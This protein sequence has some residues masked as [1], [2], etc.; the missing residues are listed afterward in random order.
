MLLL[1]GSL[2]RLLRDAVDLR[3]DMPQGGT[4]R[5][6]GSSH[7][8]IASVLDDSIA[9]R[10]ERVGVYRGAGVRSCRPGT[11]TDA[12]AIASSTPRSTHEPLP[13][14]RSLSPDLHGPVMAGAGGLPGQL[15]LQLRP[16]HG[17]RGFDVPLRG[18]GDRQLQGGRLYRELYSCCHRALSHRSCSLRS[19]V[20]LLSHVSK[21]AVKVGT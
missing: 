20:H 13:R 3:A 1:H 5:L 2:L 8:F 18:N 19:M 16:G 9:K 15:Q 6:V 10:G 17:H 11:A 14:R 4:C 21:L 12:D 7:R